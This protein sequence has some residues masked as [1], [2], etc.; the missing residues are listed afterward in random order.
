MNYV[1]VI[2]T[3]KLGD[4]DKQVGIFFDRNRL[5]L[6]SGHF[7]LVLLPS[8]GVAMTVTSGLRLSLCLNPNKGFR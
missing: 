4:K 1:T 5:I 2:A 7:L 6:L 3:Q 8:L